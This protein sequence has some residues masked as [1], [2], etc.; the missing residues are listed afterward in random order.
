MSNKKYDK[1]T[2]S[3]VAI[4]I[5]LLFSWNYIFG[6]KGLNWLPQPAPEKKVIV[7]KTHAAK[8]KTDS[9]HGTKEQKE[10]IKQPVPQKGKDQKPSVIKNTTDLKQKN[11]SLNKIKN[12][13][14]DISLTSPDSLYTLKI[15]P[16]KGAV[17]SIELNKI[18]NSSNTENV[19]LANKFNKKHPV[20]SVEQ[21]DNEWTPINIK[22]PVKTDKSVTVTR[23]FK[24]QQGQHFSLVQ[25]WTVG[26]NYNTQYD[27]TIVNDSSSILN[28][29]ELYFYA[30]A[31]PPV[32]FI[33]GDHARM[34]SHCID[35]FL[36][37]EK[38][39]NTVDAGSDDFLNNPIQFEPINWI[40]VS[41]MYYAFVLKADDKNDVINGGNY[42][43]S[44][45]GS[46]VT[47]DGT[48]KF[49][50]IGSAAR[51]QSIN[52]AAGNKF[53]WNFA[54]YAGPKDITLLGKFA[55]NAND[56]LHLM[57][58]PVMK[59]IAKWFLFALIYLKELCGGFGLAIIVLTVIIKLIFWPLTH[60]SNMSMKRMQKIQPMVKELREK[61]KDDKQKLNQATMEL[62]K[63]EKVNPL[64]GCLPMI[65]QIPVLIALYYT[66]MGAFEIRHASFLWAA[67]LTQPD[68]I[69]HIFGLA[70][71]P[72][73]ILMAATMLVQ[74]KMM[75]SATD[76]A[77]AKMMMLMPLVMLIFLYMLPSGLTLYW[78]VSQVITI[79]QL[80]YNKY[81]SK[82]QDDNKKGTNIQKK[83]ARA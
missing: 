9:Y 47:K 71:N 20:L 58:W 64:G 55:P 45:Q 13:Y 7:D 50:V 61:Y 49:P 14:P 27:V 51:E 74:Q 8:T 24:N 12:K 15:N 39:L 43:F 77:Q 33:S 32:K 52:I 10:K 4:C 83:K 3:V 31:L 79:I 36:S 26:K 57:S 66:L 30:G 41:D 65:I 81:F 60:K 28:M 72:L 37:K 67:D 69:A 35:A 80:L 1:T 18:L 5:I 75:P 42:N 54:Y 53:T 22:Q 44:N 16:V 68:T 62:Y 25:K 2:V 23:I 46:A 29:R 59:T 63:Q 82:E 73:A 6:P 19:I 56:I 40:A 76:P 11:I 17:D 48:E 38:A 21:P 78:T 70:I 34:E